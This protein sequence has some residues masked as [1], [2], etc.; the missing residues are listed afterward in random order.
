M[1]YAEM[2]EDVCE[3]LDALG[4]SECAVLGHSM[5]GK[6]AMMIALRSPSRVAGLVVADIAPV[7]YRHHN[8]GVAAA[9]RALDLSP[10]LDR[11]GA[12]AGLA[13]AVPDPAVRGFLLQ[14]LSFGAAPAWKIGLTEIAGGMAEIE[15]WPDVEP[16]VAY[17]GATLFIR[18]ERSDYVADAEWPAIRLMFPRARL[19]TVARAGH[20][21]HAEQPAAF[22]ALVGDFLEEVRG[23][24]LPSAE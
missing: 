20:W 11:R 19:E 8:A 15:G 9:M 10:G 12:D 3:T 22:A 17:Q 4:V 13:D 5:G 6:V 21:L 23:E 16:G 2:A 7:A 1:S 18:G 24:K 14:N